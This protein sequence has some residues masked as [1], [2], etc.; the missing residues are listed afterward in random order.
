M[1]KL[2][3]KFVVRTFIDY[4]TGLIKAETW[5]ERIDWQYAMAT[6]TIATQEKAVREALIALG[7]TPPPEGWERPRATDTPAPGPEALRDTSPGTGDTVP[8][9]PRTGPF[10]NEAVLFGSELFGSEKPLKVH[11]YFDNKGATYKSCG[12]ERRYANTVC[13]A[14]SDVKHIT[15]D[16]RDVTCKTCRR[17]WKRMTS[18]DN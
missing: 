5:H 1:D 11:M 16:F 2:T 6:Q 17:K 15:S 12:H 4:D 9:F 3:D 8:R 10:P 7:W 14:N 13:K 18:G